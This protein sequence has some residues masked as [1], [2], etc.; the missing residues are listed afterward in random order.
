LMEGTRIQVS[1]FDIDDS[2]YM[3][4]PH[5]TFPDD[6]FESNE[7]SYMMALKLKRVFG[8]DAKVKPV[9]DSLAVPMSTYS[10]AAMGVKDLLLEPQIQP[11]AQIA[12]R[13]ALKEPK[14]PKKPSSAYVLF[15]AKARI[16]MKDKLE[17]KHITECSRIIGDG[18]KA[19]TEKER[20]PFQ[21]QYEQAKVDY[22]RALKQYEKELSLFRSENPMDTSNLTDMD[23]SLLEKVVKLTSTDGIPGYATK[24]EYFYVL[25]FVPDLQW[26]HLIPLRKVGV[27][28]D[29]HPKHARGR[30][31]W[32]IVGE[33]EGKEIDTSAAICK[34]VVTRTMKNSADADEEQWD[35]YD[36]GETPQYAPM[37]SPSKPIVDPKKPKAVAK[38]VPV[39]A[40]PKAFSTEAYQRRGPGRPRKNHLPDPSV[41]RR[42]RGRPRKNP[43][44]PNAPPKRRGP[45][46][47][48]KNPL[49]QSIDGS[50]N[51]SFSSASVTSTSL[52][53]V[54]KIKRGRTRKN[55]LPQNVSVSASAVA[56]PVQPKRKRGRPPK[57]NKQPALHQPLTEATSPNVEEA[58][59]VKEVKTSRVRAPVSASKRP[60][61]PLFLKK[62]KKKSAE[63]VQVSDDASGVGA[64]ADNDPKQVENLHNNLKSPRRY[65]DR[66]RNPVNSSNPNESTTEGEMSVVSD[67]GEQ[68][69]KKRARVN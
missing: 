67:D 34:P 17:G 41:P 62:Y 15:C 30:P 56:E 40:P 50:T 36:D 19:L 9:A 23:T 47:P 55:P 8:K 37:F 68:P 39:K 49:P 14:K 35:I 22:A 18:W 58:M 24:Y 3:P 1:R 6:E 66:M 16:L 2:D 42:P 4:Y 21:R 52:E 29:E 64:R 26:V 13:K 63:A 12:Q 5:W 51:A 10:P 33:E 28:D 38:P 61:A 69:R 11:A 46:R 32:M 60:L 20:E 45:G 7:P 53:P 27:F 43:T 59:P 48:R 31:M 54:I 25:T 44:D 57:N 65:P